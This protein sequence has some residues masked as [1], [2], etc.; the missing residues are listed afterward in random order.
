[1]RVEKLIVGITRASPS[2]PLQGNVAHLILN[3]LITSILEETLLEAQCAFHPGYSTI[4]MVFAVWQLQDRC[5]K[6]KID[7]YATFIDLTKAFD[8]VKREALWSMLLKLGCPRRFINLIYLFHD[9]MSGVVLSRGEFSDSFVISYGVQQVCV[10]PPV[11]FNLFFACVFTHAVRNLD[12]RVYLR[13]RLDG[14][15]FD[16]IHLSAKSK[17]LE[18]MI[19]EALFANDCALMAHKES[20]LKLIMDRFL[21]ASH[22]FCLTISLE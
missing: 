13:Q 15:L 14:S 7:L 12:H 6:P 10:L 5:I 16:L 9:D 22:Q 21:E 19:L 11:L 17:T 2:Y 4:D 1:M 8:I 20:D 3:H 18:R